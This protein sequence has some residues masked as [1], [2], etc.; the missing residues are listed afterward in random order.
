MQ[1][2][3]FCEEPPQPDGATSV[4]QRRSGTNCDQ[5]LEQSLDGADREAHASGTSAGASGILLQVNV[6]IDAL[7]QRLHLAWC[8]PRGLL[9]QSGEGQ[10]CAGQLRQ[11]EAHS[12]ATQPCTNAH[13]LFHHVPARVRIQKSC[14]NGGNNLE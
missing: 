13:Q 5:Q 14:R 11:E 6:R 3:S 2:A 7:L 1:V 8:S 12:G 9:G 4:T 10:V